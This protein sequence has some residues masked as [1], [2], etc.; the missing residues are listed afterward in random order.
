VT[1]KIAISG[2][3]L[4]SDAWVA[5][6]ERSGMKVTRRDLLVWSAG[7]AAGLLATPVPWKVLDDVS[8]WSQN[9]P[10]IP[11]A[12][13][14]PVEVKQSFCTLCPNGCGL[15]VRMAGGW[16]VGVAG[17]DTNPISR[18]ALCPLGFGAHQLNWH[19][20]RLR[21]V[22]HFA[23]ASSWNDAQAAFARARSEGPI[24]IIDGWPGRAASS[25]LESFAQKQGGSYRV[26]AGAEIR[27]LARYENW[28]GVPATS[29]G[30][31]LEN[32]QTIVSF[33]APL[34]DGWGTPGRFTRLWAERAAGK[35]DPRVRLIQV[36]PS[37]SRTASRAWQWI[38]V[39]EG[40]ESA[41]AAGLARVLI[42]QK[43]V[44][45]H[46]PIP[47]VTLA[48]VATLT[49]LTAD[50]IRE[51]ARTIA[52]RMP[53][54]AISRDDDPAIAALNVVMG[55]VGARGGI[56]RRSKNAPSYISAEISI[57][58][59]RAVLVDASVPWNFVPQTGAEVFRFAAWDGASNNSA[60]LLPAPGFLEELTDVPSAPTSAVETYAV[61]PAL[62]KATSDVRSAAQFLSALDPTLSSAEKIIHARCTDLFRARSGRLCAQE[63]MP[64]AQI[65][66]L[67]KLEEEMWKGAVWVGEPSPPGGLRCQLKEWPAIAASPRVESWA[68][69]WTVPVL[70]PLASKIYI[71]SNLREAPARRNA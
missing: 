26:A 10:W 70:P 15:R 39:R 1:A 45:A 53:A 67:Q 4:K 64:V 40:S 58:N 47:S 43:L 12:S 9:W 51:L 30:Y 50:A 41:L 65:A 55:A 17:V 42:E 46:G 28:S 21:T 63:T 57:A 33:G 56:V 59:A 66:S 7:A 27:A 24:V 35:E 62:V 6:N 38:S 23:G 71:E 54:V 19:P 44:P 69:G 29:L 14:G 25:V 49:G 36:E 13:R 32:A 11:Q 8:I 3:T 16:P 18:G 31:D 2:T 22:R 20:Q 48:E 68:S 60:W 34:L 52:A 61:A 37:L 5:T